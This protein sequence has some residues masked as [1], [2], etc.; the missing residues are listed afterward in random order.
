MRLL[1]VAPNISV[2][3]TNGGSTHVTEVVAGLRRHHD[4]LLAARR[5]SR[6]PDTLGIGL[7]SAA[8]LA[9]LHAAAIY[10]AARR[11]RSQAVYERFSARGAGVLLGRALGVP[12]ISM[13]LDTDVSPLTWRGAARLITTA[14][15]LVPDQYQHKV[16]RVSWGANIERFRPDISAP[17]LRERLGF[18]PSDF[19]LV[20][21][22]AF[23]HWHGLDILVRAVAEL[24]RAGAAGPLKVLLVGDGKT[25]PEIER[26][27]GEL[28]Q[29][30]RIRFAGVVPYEEVPNYISIADAC[31]AVYDPSRHEAL[32]SHGMFFDPLKIFE[33]LACGKPTLILDTENMRAIFEQ[34]R[35]ACLVT[36]GDVPAL[37]RAI[38]RLMADPALRARLGAEGRQLVQGRY[39]WQA[40]ADH[41]GELFEELV[42]ERGRAKPESAVS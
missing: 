40:H 31:T 23:Y 35:H 24:D 11:F 4:V 26:L 42:A 3:G 19:L 34:E 21:T 7:G 16:V 22:G 20:Y 18:T 39:S 25:R 37:A 2:P 36:T 30:H 33:Y 6:G 9:P 41:L 38:E 27:T 29:R 12:V 5:G 28:G 1:F 8:V 13:V 14:P 15:H 17:G 32:A 10:P